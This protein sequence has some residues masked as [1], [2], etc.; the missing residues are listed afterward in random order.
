[1]VSLAPVHPSI[2]FWNCGG[3]RPHLTSGALETLTHPSFT[4]Q[5]PSIVVLTETHWSAT[6]AGHR[7]Q[8]GTELPPISG[9]TWAHRHHTNLSG[10]LAVL[11]H[12]SVACLPMPALDRMTNPIS[13]SPTSAAR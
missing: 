6:K 3:L 8:N 9:Y 13:A 4:P 7:S 5:R 1:M 10:G 11:Y 12:S 2:V